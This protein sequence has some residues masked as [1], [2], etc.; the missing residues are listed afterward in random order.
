MRADDERPVRGL[1]GVQNYPVVDGRVSGDYDAICADHMPV[2]SRYLR[3]FSILD[4][5]GV[6]RGEDLTT[7]ADDSLGQA[8]QVLEG[9]KLRLAR[10]TESWSGVP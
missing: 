2:T 6:G 1:L 7:V 5:V 10:K 9:V 3:R 8:V 4:L